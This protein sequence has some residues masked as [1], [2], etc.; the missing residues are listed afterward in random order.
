MENE[1]RDGIHGEENG[2]PL[3]VRTRKRRRN[4]NKKEQRKVKRNS[5]KAYVTSKGKHVAEKIFYNPPCGCKIKCSDSIT[6]EERKKLFDHFYS[7]GS[8]QVQNA[9]ICGLCKQ[10]TPKAHR[11]RDGSRGM[12]S[13]TVSYHLQLSDK[14]L[15][16]C[17]Q[18]FL[19]TFQ[20]S[21]GRCFR[22]LR[23]IRDGCEP[24]S[25]LRGVQP[26]VNKIDDARIQIVRNHIES[27]P[28][29]QSHYTR[30]HNPDRKYLSEFLNIRT[31]FNLYKE[32]CNNINAIPVSESKYRYI[33]NYEYNLHF[34]APHKDT[35]AKCDILGL[36]IAACEDLQKKQE[37]ETSKEL[38]LRKAELA[39][40][41]LKQAKED[42]KNDNSKIY[43][44]TFDLQKALAFP[45]LTCSVAYY[46]RNMYVYNVG[47]HELSSDSAY[48]Y[49]WDETVASRGSQEIV[50][51]LVEHLRN[52]VSENNDHVIMFSDSCG[53]Q[54]RNIKVS[55][56]CMKF[57]QEEGTNI[58]IIDQKFMTSGHSFLPN[59]ADFGVIESYSKG[60]TMNVPQDWFNAIVTS[61]RK[62][63]Y[64]L[65]V[66]GREDIYS[67]ANLEKAI[68]RRRK[69]TVGEKVSWH[70][71]QWL[72]Y[73]REEPYKIFYKET[74]N[75]D[76]DFFAIDIAPAR[77]GRKAA[78][79]GL[80]P[81]ELLYAGQRPVT[82]AKK[83][84]MLDLLP[85]IP[86]VNHGYF[87]N[88]IDE[89][90]KPP[91]DDTPII[92]RQSESESEDE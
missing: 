23:K 41:K 8:F 61:K 2:I 22:A 28:A 75:E 6:E 81:V 36:K 39:R 46:K 73:L 87:T 43:A 45:T 40:Q 30:A 57:L 80:I 62:K 76:I 10:S 48:M 13:S 4:P 64:L 79:L 58:K 33:F 91:A 72:R 56:M 32:H 37:L 68:T 1:N 90:D 49:A 89:S 53:G 92:D 29:Y 70:K 35:C 17:K 34:H 9:Y 3:V 14:N 83:R 78:H 88:L 24:G 86:P 60:R 21:D 42:S 84:D 12:K 71:I 38:H 55:L 26:S 52:K 82:S 11:V 69:N 67:T 63:P 47:C 27:F 54:N 25:D 31:L 66:M 51:C 77:K 16:V 15:K 18:Y 7:I 20:I 85:Y 44:L 65:K 59:D 74:L 19:K 5:G 50:S